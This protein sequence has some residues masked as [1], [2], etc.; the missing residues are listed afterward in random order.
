MIYVYTDGA[1]RSN[2]GES[3][4]GYRIFDSGHKVVMSHSFYNGIRTNNEAEYLA[5]I[6]ALEK[7][8]EMFG[9]GIEVR[10][11]SDSQLVIR[12]LNGTYKVKRSGLLE[13]NRKAAEIV[14]KFKSCVL[15]NVSREERHIREVDADLNV[16][17]DSKEDGA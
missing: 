12:Q 13:L 9:F 15:E 5:V 1:S 17:L 6:A 2:P 11:C 10:L 3:A 14:G 16:L 8:A 7:A 4:S